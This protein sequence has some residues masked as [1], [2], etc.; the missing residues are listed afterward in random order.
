MN[1]NIKNY[2]LRMKTYIWPPTTLSLYKA[3]EWNVKIFANDT[4]PTV[5]NHAAS[6]VFYPPQNCLLPLQG[7]ISSLLYTI[8]FLF[9]FVK[10]HFFILH[11][12]CRVFGGKEHIFSFVC[13]APS[14][15]KYWCF[16]SVNGMH[17]KTREIKYYQLTA[18][19][20]LF[21]NLLNGLEYTNLSGKAKKAY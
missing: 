15:M 8:F 18:T 2:I 16:I 9:V 10:I 5:A 11:Y 13:P 4:V 17:A 21:K 7:F 14:A 19:Y 20:Y 3:S 1:R 12:D 6:L